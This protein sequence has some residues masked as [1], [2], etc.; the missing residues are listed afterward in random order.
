MESNNKYV[1][2]ALNEE[3]E[4]KKNEATEEKSNETATDTKAEDE[5]NYDVSL[6]IDPIPFDDD[7]VTMFC[8]TRQLRDQIDRIFHGMFVDYVG[9]EIMVNTGFQVPKIIETTIP[10]GGLYVNLLFGPQPDANGYH[11]LI[12]K[13]TSNP[14]MP[15]YNRVTTTLG[16]APSDVHAYRVDETAAIGLTEILPAPYNG[17]FNKKAKK[18]PSE[19]Y[20]RYY[21]DQVSQQ[22]YMQMQGFNPANRIICRIIGFPMELV[23]KKIYGGQDE[24]QTQIDYGVHIIRDLGPV[25]HLLQITRMKQSTVSKIYRAMSS[26]GV[27]MPNMNI[28]ANAYYGNPMVN[29][30]MR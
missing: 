25:D 6:D 14:K 7:A 5:E 1:N 28:G 24:D 3:E 19:I 17:I 8:S 12:A 13:Q 30:M 18:N 4:A 9:C 10:V 16:V 2:K 27:A 11:V 20:N 15:M 29:S 22:N 23:L 26:C 21:E